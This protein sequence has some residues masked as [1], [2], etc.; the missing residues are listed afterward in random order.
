[1]KILHFPKNYFNIFSLIVATAQ[2]FRLI[3]YVVLLHVAVLGMTFT[4]WMPVLPSYRN[5]GN[6]DI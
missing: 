1:M 5:Q 6:T 3:D 4:N 2:K